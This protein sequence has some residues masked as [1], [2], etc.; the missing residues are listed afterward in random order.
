[1]PTRV[2]R[3]PQVL[4]RTGYSRSGLYARISAGLFPHPI[5]LGARASAWP[6]HEVEAVLAAQIR[7]VDEEELRTVVSTLEGE[8]ANFGLTGTH[9]SAA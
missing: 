1:M 3:L 5:A 9:A 6:E 7:S 2:L 8:R 4:E